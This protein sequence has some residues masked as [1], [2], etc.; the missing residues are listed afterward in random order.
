MPARK[1]TI[2]EVTDKKILSDGKRSVGIYSIESGH[3]AGTLIGMVHDARIGFTTDIWSPGRDPL[4]AKASPGMI[5]LVKGIQRHGLDPERIAGGH[6]T[7][8]SYRDLA[9]LVKRTAALP[10]PV[11]AGRVTP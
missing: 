8:G 3:S 6:G 2:I 1:A 10:G 4:P 7:F 9:A 11:M 5:D